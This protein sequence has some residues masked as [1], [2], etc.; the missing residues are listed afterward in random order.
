VTKLKIGDKESQDQFANNLR[1]T[2]VTPELVL[3]QVDKY[4]Q[5]DRSGHLYGAIIAS[6]RDYIELKKKGR[7]AEYHLAYAAQYIGD[8]SQPLHRTLYEDF[9]KKE[10]LENGRG[11]QRWYFR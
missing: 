3:A 10:P 6:V 1:Y 4:N 5:Y 11:G 7:Y 2:T 8:L 9:N